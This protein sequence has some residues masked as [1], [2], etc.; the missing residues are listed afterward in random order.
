[1]IHSSRE[2][3]Q[4]NSK[5]NYSYI[6]SYS[7]WYYQVANHSRCR[8]PN[9]LDGSLGKQVYSWQERTSLSPSDGHY[10]P[11]RS[12]S[13]FSRT[14]SYTT[15]EGGGWVNTW[16]RR[17][18]LVYV[19]TCLDNVVLE[20]GMTWWVRQVNRN[21]PRRSLMPAMTSRCRNMSG[22][23]EVFESRTTIEIIECRIIVVI[24][25]ALHE[26]FVL[27]AVRLLGLLAPVPYVLSEHTKRTD[28]TSPI[29][30]HGIYN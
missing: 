3:T 13:I 25:L 28:G 23:S 18:A 2:Q 22:D 5:A 17:L 15:V 24:L 12:I 6:F 10:W 27:L 16:S 9:L 8:K 21:R 7:E 1:M 11:T 26:C 30:Y 14:Y 19:E 4:Y 29:T 20:Q